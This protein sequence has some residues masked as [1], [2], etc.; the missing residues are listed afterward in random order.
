[1]D[2]YKDFKSIKKIYKLY[3][4]NNDCYYVGIKDT[5]VISIDFIN[6]LLDDRF[7]LHTIDKASFKGRAIDID[8]INPITARS[9]TGS[10]SGTAIN[11]FWGINDLG[12]GTDGGGSVLAPALSLNLYGFISPLLDE[13][14]LKQYEKT[15]TDGI[16]FTPSI[17]FIAKSIN[18]IEDVI[19]KVFLSDNYE[20]NSTNDIFISN[21]KLIYHKNIYNEVNELF[22]N[23]KSIDLNYSGL[24]RSEMINELVSIDFDNNIL[25]TFE[26]PIDVLGYGDSVLGHYSSFTK[27][28]QSL[29]HKYY[30]KV[31][32][33][34]NLSAFIVPASDLAVGTLI[35]CKSDISHILY[36]LELAKRIK[37]KRSSLEQSYFSL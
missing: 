34:L 21:P 23:Y 15:S 16:K 7:V 24:N 8:L 28:I 26:G 9:M 36:A 5:D 6:K 10:S 32:N 12:V 25:I 3:K 14:N 37:F 29:G 35:I 19:N 20:I 17:G 11:V 1:M 33:M 18:V 27:D 4:I 2:Y 13:E 30:L 22:I 31:V